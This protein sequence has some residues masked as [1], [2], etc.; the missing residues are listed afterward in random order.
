MSDL[1]KI[2]KTGN[3]YDFTNALNSGEDI[4]QT[5]YMGQNALMIALNNDR[6]E[7]ACFIIENGGRPDAADFFGR[8]AR[9]I[10]EKKQN[11]TVLKLLRSN[12]ESPAGDPYVW[13]IDNITYI[14][15]DINPLIKKIDPAHK[16]YLAEDFA[17]VMVLVAKG[18][19]FSKLHKFAFSVMTYAITTPENERRMPELKK[20]SYGI[21]FDLYEQNVKFFEKITQPDYDFILNSFTL[22][23]ES[24][25]MILKK[26]LYQFAQLMIKADGKVTQQEVENLQAVNK[27]YLSVSQSKSSADKANEKQEPSQGGEKNLDGLLAELDNLVG[28]ENIKEDIRSLINIISANKARAEQGL[29]QVKTSLH[30][31]FMGPPGTGKTTIARMLADIYKELG[32]LPANNFVETD[33]SGLVAGFVGQTAIKTDAIIK[34]AMDGVLFIDEAY[35]LAR[36]IGENDYG[37]EAIDILL[38]RMEDHRDELIVIVAGYKAEMNGFINSN[39]G[40]QSRFSRSFYFKD[41]TPDELLEIFKKMAEKGG[42]VLTSTAANRFK[43][44]FEELYNN[45]NRKFGNAR[46]VRNIFEKTFEVHA[47]RTAS[48]VPITREILITLEEADVPY[49]FFIQ[50]ASVE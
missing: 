8:T 1:I 34:K 25:L 38:K 42:F 29:P 13:L 14:I 49:A 21:I 37:Q 19:E 27:E 45:R 12:P 35:T 4:N 31:V 24:D 28:L 43:K 33:R 40:L 10:A 46:L 41:Y 36:S 15:D 6:T 3:V 30:A 11:L 23:E 48:I 39:P 44:L 18:E 9:E 26:S 17:K 22:Y 47:N 20:I 32:V 16:P 50:S 7:L 2:A 5:N